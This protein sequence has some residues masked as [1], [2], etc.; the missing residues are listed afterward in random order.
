M[1][2]PL[3]L[4]RRLVDALEEGA[5][6]AAHEGLGSP[7]WYEHVAEARAFLDGAVEF[8]QE[9]VQVV[10]RNGERWLAATMSTNDQLLDND[11]QDAIRETRTLHGFSTGPVTVTVIVRPRGDG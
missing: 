4:I 1:T 8:E 2:T 6:I 3:D 7:S 9:T 5:A 10:Q 11:Y